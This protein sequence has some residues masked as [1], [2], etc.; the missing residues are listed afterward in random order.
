M[1]VNWK[2]LLGGVAPIL[3]KAMLGPASAAVPAV[4]ALSRALL[5]HEKGSDVEVAAALAGASPEQMAKIQDAER[6][7][8]LKLV[9]M[10]VQLEKIEADDRASAREREAKTGDNWTPR[11]LAA[12]VVGGFLATVYMVLAGHVAGLRDPM[13]SGLVGTLIGYVSAKADQVVGYYF[14]SSA[15]SRAK[16]AVL[17]RLTRR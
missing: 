10:A 11:I 3:A 15:S 13:M 17:S 14:G 5:G 6:E 9:D 7:F 2:G 16:D 8:A 4:A 12:V 1:A